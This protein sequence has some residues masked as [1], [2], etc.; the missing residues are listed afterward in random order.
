MVYPPLPSRSRDSR[1]AHLA[2]GTRTL[3]L[4]PIG[5]RRRRRRC[6]VIS[7]LRSLLPL[8]LLLLPLSRYVEAHNPPAATLSRASATW[9]RARR[10]GTDGSRSY[11]CGSPRPNCCWG[12]V[13]CCCALP[14]ALHRPP[15]AWCCTPA[16]IDIVEFV[17]NPFW[18][19]DMPANAQCVAALISDRIL[20]YIWRIECITFFATRLFVFFFLSPSYRIDGNRDTR[21]IASLFIL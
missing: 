20:E 4:F 5:K 9:F 8:L 14:D 10:L 2:R 7:S 19:G 18:L 12:C 21:D 1:F 17:C 6:V 16:A 15:A 13:V 11:L 3:R